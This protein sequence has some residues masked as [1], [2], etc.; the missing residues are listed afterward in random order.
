MQLDDYI[1]LNKLVRDVSTKSVGGLTEK[2]LNILVEGVLSEFETTI[3]NSASNT[4][5]SLSGVLSVNLSGYSKSKVREVLR[6]A[7]YRL[8]NRVS[9]KLNKENRKFLDY[10]IKKPSSR[11]VKEIKI[12]YEECG[13]SSVVAL[14]IIILFFFGTVGILYL[15][16]LLSTVL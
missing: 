13:L 11:F 7:E 15:V 10:K 8:D 6:E 16:Q 5:K 4:Q 3:S 1:R 9:F 12:F 2:D 14:A